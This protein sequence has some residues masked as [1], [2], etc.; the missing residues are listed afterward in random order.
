MDCSVSEIQEKN[1]RLVVPLTSRIKA[2]DTMRQISD[3]DS[4]SN[5]DAAFVFQGWTTCVFP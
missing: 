3:D 5:T 2:C 4:T 1:T